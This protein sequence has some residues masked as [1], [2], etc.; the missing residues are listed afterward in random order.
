M[1]K[2]SFA[3]VF[4]F[5]FLFCAFVPLFVF[6]VSAEANPNLLNFTSKGSVSNNWSSLTPGRYYM[7]LHYF[8]TSYY[9]LVNVNDVS[10]SFDSSSG[11]VTYSGSA[12]YYTTAFCF[13]VLSGTSYSFSGSVVSGS[14]YFQIVFFDSSW[15]P[16]P[17]IFSDGNG[18]TANIPLNTSFVAPSDSTYA[19][20]YLCAPNPTNVVVAN[21]SLR[22][23]DSLSSPLL[24]YS[25]KGLLFWSSV[26]NATSYS[27]EYALSSDAESW[28]WVSNVTSPVDLTQFYVD[29]YR[30]RYFHVYAFADGYVSSM[31][32][33]ALVGTLSAP[34]VSIEHT[35]GDTLFCN[36]SGSQNVDIDVYKD[37][38][39]YRTLTYPID[40]F[41]LTESGS[42]SCIAYVHGSSEFAWY[43]S[44]FSNTVDYSGSS[45]P[46]ATQALATP[47][48]SVSGRSVSW[49]SVSNAVGYDVQI[50]SDA[51]FS[52]TA[53]IYDI[54]FV[55]DTYYDV[56]DS[57]L[58]VRV[59]A[60]AR[61][62]S[63]Y[64]DSSWS[65]AVVSSDPT[66]D[67]TAPVLS[68]SGGTFTWTT[69]D[70]D[71]SPSYVL[72]KGENT[73]VYSGTG[74]SYT[75]SSN[76]VY[77]VYSVKG[78]SV[79]ERSNSITVEFAESES[80]AYWR[81]Y[82]QGQSDVEGLKEVINAG[83]SGFVDVFDQFTEQTS[84]GGITLISILVSIVI[85]AVVAFVI[86]LIAKG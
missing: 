27:L 67:L 30:P 45:E 71:L 10:F 63:L 32:S 49:D 46:P 84:I 60:S 56:E 82:H 78:S 18:L 17:H 23:V 65:T 37:G 3:L 11:N 33:F 24:S 13:S 8:S 34:L 43:P 41:S 76:G 51:S 36:Y 74:N 85:I 2:R 38:L 77:S 7:G 28:N 64:T 19:L 48:V 79:S 40:S 15:N 73:P 39:F 58:Y 70:S 54:D 4:A 83:W 5:L 1:K 47:S 72:V 6:P 44:N 26:P 14:A 16:L 57:G 31:S 52:P 9:K 50:C 53:S 81:G 21:L 69:P 68:Y 59:R 42:Y 62:D 61:A 66:Y 55:T 35:G 22:E 20:L 75:V 29:G 86:K 12:S 25:S 80:D